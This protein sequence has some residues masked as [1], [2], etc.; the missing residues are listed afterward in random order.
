MAKIPKDPLIADYKTIKTLNSKI[1]YILP[2]YFITDYG[3][4]YGKTCVPFAE[5]FA[6]LKD[7]Y[8]P[9]ELQNVLIDGEDFSTHDRDNR[10]SGLECSINGDM[11]CYKSPERTNKDG[12]KVIPQGVFVRRYPREEANTVKNMFY[13]YL[14]NMDLFH[15]K[16]LPYQPI[17]EYQLGQI[18]DQ[19]EI[20][21]VID[22]IGIIIDQSL[23]PDT[24]RQK[25]SLPKISATLVPRNLYPPDN[26]VRDD[27]A[28]FIIKQD[29]EWYDSYALLKVMIV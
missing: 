15:L 27:E 19:N 20:E 7:E 8:I 14:N 25:K 23:F 11:I 26:N 13:R 16:A 10:L 5:Q 9:L 3:L 28:L 4:V 2:M 12:T 17:S 6:N 22:G 1:K 21:I 24:A 29:T 18:L